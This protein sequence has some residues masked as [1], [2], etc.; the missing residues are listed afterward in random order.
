MRR[1]FKIRKAA[2]TAVE[3]DNCPEGSLGMHLCKF[4]RTHYKTGLLLLAF[5]FTGELGWVGIG[6]YYVAFATVANIIV[7]ITMLVYA[8]MR[9]EYMELILIRTL[10]LLLNLPIAFA[11]FLIVR[12]VL[13]TKLSLM[14]SRSQIRSEDNIHVTRE[15]FIWSLGF[16]TAIALAFLITHWEGFLLPGFFYLAGAF[17]TNLIFFINNV[18]SIC[19]DN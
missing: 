10:L 15:L 4:L 16:G 14:K 18:V 6:L 2:V 7:L 1:F 13:K 11:Y 5:L 19:T 3:L 12:N 17:F 8:L 9:R